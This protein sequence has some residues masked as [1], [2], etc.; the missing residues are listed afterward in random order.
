M[1]SRAIALWLLLALVA[2]AHALTLLT[3]ENAPLN[4]TDKGKV[5]GFSTE[6]LEEMGRRAKIP[7][8]IEVLDWKVAY[9]RAQSAK[10]TCIYSTARL[11]NRE[12]IFRWVGPVAYTRWGVYGKQGFSAP[13]KSIADLKPF[14]IGGVVYDAK[15]EFLK[16]SGVTNISEVTEDRM[17][18]PKLTTD[19]KAVDR[20]DLWV[21]T[22]ANAK[23][24][25]AKAG[26][27]DL[28]LVYV[29]R[30]AE[31]F[32]ACS[33]AT[34][35]ATTKALDDALQSMRKDKSWNRIADKYDVK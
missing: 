25:A 33:P 23:N 31:S 2:P 7:M 24:I 5:T 29:V 26:V 4:Y 13:V 30:E 32:L 15:T 20:I 22:V 17:N 9:E 27:T 19:R 14:R 1:T 34:A 6:V 3:E 28:K 11:E 12:R 8:T 18:P 35:S 10:D 16:Q 21:T